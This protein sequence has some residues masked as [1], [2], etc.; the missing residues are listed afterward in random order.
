MESN[1]QT[2]YQVREKEKMCSLGG[3]TWRAA[4]LIPSLHY[5]DLPLCLSNSN[6]SLKTLGSLLRPE[7]LWFP[8]ALCS[9]FH[10]S[11]C[12][13]VSQPI[14]LPLSSELFGERVRVI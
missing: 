1:K 14:C 4:A 11:K 5:S 10:G 9:Q 2:N 12:Q 3:V 13:Q 7:L 6:S 8:V